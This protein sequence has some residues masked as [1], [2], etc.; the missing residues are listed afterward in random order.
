MRLPSRVHLWSLLDKLM[1]K[2]IRHL[3]F[4]KV[5]TRHWTETALQHGRKKLR[6]ILRVRIVCPRRRCHNN[7]HN[8]QKLTEQQ[9][10]SSQWWC[11][12]RRTASVCILLKLAKH[13]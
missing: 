6:Q 5:R 8:Q 10:L 9:S 4:G 11:P 13:P 7:C 2:S 3:R 12:A 1:H